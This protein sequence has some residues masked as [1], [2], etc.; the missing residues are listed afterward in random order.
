MKTLFNPLKSVSYITKSKTMRY[1]STLFASLL[2]VLSSTSRAQNS[3]GS[4]DL[5]E[6]GPNDSW[7]R[8]I[9]S[10]TSDDSLSG[11][12][13]TLELNVTSLPLEGANYRV[14][15][16]VA[17]GNWFFGNATPLQLGANM[18]TVA[19]VD[20]DRSV[21]FQFSSA[22]VEF[23]ALQVNGE[24]L[25]CAIDLAGTA[26]SDCSGVDNGPNSTWPYVVTSTTSDDP[27]SSEAQTMEILV[28]SLPIEG[29]SFRVVK[30]VANGNW[31][32]GAPVAL[33]IGSNAITVSAVDFVRSVKFQFSSGDIEF[34]ELT[35][36]GENIV[37][38]SGSCVDIDS[39]D[40]CDDVDDC[41]GT[42]DALGVCNGVCEEDANANGICDADE[43]FVDPSSYCGPGTAWDEAIQQCVGVE[44]CTGDLDGDGAVATADL[45][46]FLAVFGG[47]CN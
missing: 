4:C 34:A 8:V 25:T 47:I 26:M 19:G 33:E 21:K 44:S 32:N 28:T 42:L 6:D 5:F 36:N 23:D 13:Q 29:G 2:L 17:N 40:I 15:K 7:P 10:T 46:G 20:F 18:V 1:L 45:L 24:T 30:T 43:D 3:I 9:T 35:L 38:E 37:C 27:S 12:V 16:T 41:V 39:D 22:E 11:D 14:A 31:N